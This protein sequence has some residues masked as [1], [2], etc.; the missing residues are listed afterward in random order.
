M[1]TPP[2]QQAANIRIMQRRLGVL[3]DGDFGPRTLSAFLA[4]ADRAE[5]K[6]PMPD[7]QRDT[8]PDGT[9][10]EERATTWCEREADYWMA[11]PVDHKRVAEYFELCEDV[12]GTTTKGQW[13]ASETRKGRNLSFCAAAQGFAERQVLLPGEVPM[14]VRAGAKQYRYEAIRGRRGPWV[15]VDDVR[16]GRVIPPPRGSLAIYDRPSTPETW[17]GHIRRVRESTPKGYLGVGANENN[18]RWVV[19]KAIVPWLHMNLIGFVYPRG[20]IVS[21]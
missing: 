19:D 17:D 12:D 14:A 2:E 16:R 9:S 15:S 6:D 20:A 8:I 5:G 18:R 4:L 7:T 10:I 21:L 1:P 11:N 3:D 13:L